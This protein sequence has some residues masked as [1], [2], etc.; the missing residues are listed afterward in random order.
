MPFQSKAQARYLYAQHP[1]IA[2]RWEKHTPKKKQRG[3]P[4]HVSKES[5]ARI[6]LIVASAEKVASHA[7]GT[8]GHSA[9]LA[10][11]N[12][13]IH[14]HLLTRPRAQRMDAAADLR[15]HAR[16]HGISAKAE[17]YVGMDHIRQAT[18]QPHLGIVGPESPHWAK[19][20]KANTSRKHTITVSQRPDEPSGVKDSWTGPE[21]SGN[22]QELSRRRLSR[23]AKVLG[24]YKETKSYLPN[25]HG[26]R[27][28]PEVTSA[29]RPLATRKRVV[30]PAAAITAGGAAALAAHK[31]KKAGKVKVTVETPTARYQRHQ[32]QVAAGLTATA[33][34]PALLA[35]RSGRMASTAMAAG[36]TAEHALHASSQLKHAASATA[37]GGLAGASN[38]LPVPRRLLGEPKSKRHRYSAKK[39]SAKGYTKT[40][41]GKATR[42]QRDRMALGAGTAGIVAGTS[43]NRVAAGYGHLARGFHTGGINRATIQQR[44]ARSTTVRPSGGSWAAHGAAQGLDAGAARRAALAP[45]TAKLKAAT[46]SINRSKAGLRAI[47]AAQRVVAERT[48]LIGFG[49]GIPLAY[50][51]ARGLAHRNPRKPVAK[52]VYRRDVDS[53]TAGGLAGAGAYH[54]IGYGSKPLE[55]KLINAKIAASP[56]HTALFAQHKAAHGIGANH[57]AG[58][59]EWKPMFRSYPKALPGST[60]KRT[61]AR[62]H[63]GKTGLAVQGAVITAAAAGT[64]KEIRARRGVTKKN[65]ENTM[66][67]DAFGIDRSDLV[68]KRGVHHFDPDSPESKAADKKHKGHFHPAFVRHIGAH[69]FDH[70]AEKKSEKDSKH[71]DKDDKP[72]WG[73]GRF[74]PKKGH[75]PQKKKM[76]AA[77]ADQ[78]GKRSAAK[79]YVAPPAGFDF[80]GGARM[81]DGVPESQHQSFIETIEPV[82]KDYYYGS[83]PTHRQRHPGA[84]ASTAAFT[85]AA[86]GAAAAPQLKRLK[87]IGPKAKAVKLALK[88]K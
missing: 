51:G 84:G 7:K 36:K 24:S 88:A 76:P 85:G 46:S 14:Q 53:A 23:S 75:K 83:A 81:V 78:I 73:N 54:G 72:D 13:N 9:A 20:K 40:G 58:A 48:A 33:A 4:E 39:P 45:R 47:P 28:R 3:L 57:P 18:G 74:P 27:L 8:P 60:L 70:N 19:I 55:R 69:S 15:R 61:L 22:H 56:E 52:R 37:L 26:A 2:A 82:E 31:I 62:T 41:I 44:S 11:H 30:I 67:V 38:A 21:T 50:M 77:F 29:Y 79:S 66:S 1:E 17:K 86:V 63:S 35:L 65:W 59:P 16:N 64:T 87:A 71:T 32:H 25:P 49:A 43:Q 6:G 5:P 10:V 42:R 68:D 80:D 34:V 12:G